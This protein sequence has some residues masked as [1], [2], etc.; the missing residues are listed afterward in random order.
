MNAEIIGEKAMIVCQDKC[1]GYL[2]T[3]VKL[4]IKPYVKII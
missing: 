4:Q 1:I 2:F 3:K